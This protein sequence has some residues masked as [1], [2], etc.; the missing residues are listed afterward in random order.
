M[1]LLVEERKRSHELLK[2]ISSI[3]L[4]LHSTMVWCILPGKITEM[5]EHQ[6]LQKLSS[7]SRRRRK[8]QRIICL[9]IFGNSWIGPWTIS[10][11]ITARIIWFFFQLG[12][13]LISNWPLGLGLFM[14]CT[15]W[16]LF[17]GF[18]LISD[19]TWKLEKLTYFAL[20][21]FYYLFIFLSNLLG[22]LI[23]DFRL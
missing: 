14:F 12:P 16:P 10:N 5:L 18:C 9:Q 23:L 6:G 2:L 7:K 3:S 1:R 8:L 22:K 13:E 20:L 17:L 4:F 15:Y 11:F 19:R 21:D